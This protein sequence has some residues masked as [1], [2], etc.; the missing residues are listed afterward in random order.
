MTCFLFWGCNSID[1]N[2]L[3]GYWKADKV[4]EAGELLEIDLSE[5]AFE[6]KSNA[7]YSYYNTPNLSEEGR[8]EVS[9]NR[10]I[11]IDTTGANPMKKAVEIIHLDQDSLHIRMNYGGK[12]QIL[13]LFRVQETEDED[14]NIEEDEM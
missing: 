7:H 2:Q 10:L 12:E 14:L 1:N 8:Y 4:V 9:G 11:T 13:Y 3:Q 5:I 6:F